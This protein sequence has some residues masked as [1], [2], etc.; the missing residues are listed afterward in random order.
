MLTAFLLDDEPLALDRLERLLAADGRL[1]I[2]GRSSDPLDA[3]ARIAELAPDL[4]FLD[5]QMPEI[6]GF[7]LLDRLAHQ[8]LV[9]F[10][11]AFDQHALRAFETN[12]VAYLLKPIEQA[13]L[14]A[15]IDKVLRIGAGKES[16][17]DLRHLLA[18]LSQSIALPA[19]RKYPD[20]IGSK[21][22][23]RVE[24]IDLS[25]VTHFYAEDKLTYA[26]TEAKAF[27]VDETISDLE[28]RLDPDR[29]LRIHRATLVNLAYVGELYTYF[30]GKLILRL[31]DGKR[32]ELTVARDRAR[33]LRLKLGV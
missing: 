13:K 2:A 17:P 29:F 32:T 6:D 16:P 26:A 28:Q 27:I 22:G 25:R 30:A 20:R 9:I 1:A 21:V 15:A 18:Q 4:L 3:L 5:I 7:Q 11:T 24:L 12:S 8:P 14:T 33:D 19:G 23:D 31:K 10:T